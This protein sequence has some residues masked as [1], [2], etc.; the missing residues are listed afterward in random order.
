MVN[1]LL[2]ASVSL[3]VFSWDNLLINVNMKNELRLDNVSRKK[4]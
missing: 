4:D 3:D 2:L 1:W